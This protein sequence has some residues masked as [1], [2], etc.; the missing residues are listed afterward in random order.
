MVGTQ[1]PKGEKGQLGLQGD[2]GLRGILLVLLTVRGTV[3][4]T[5]FFMHEPNG[6]HEPGKP[7]PGSANA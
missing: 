6:G 5:S 1:G 2:K 7:P 4:S 3:M